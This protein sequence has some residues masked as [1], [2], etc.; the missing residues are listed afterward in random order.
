HLDLPSFPTRRSSD[1]RFMGY[2]ER[3]LQAAGGT[4]A[5][6]WQLSYVDLSLFQLVT[7]LRYAFP[8]TMARLESA[9]PALIALH[10][11]IAMRPNIRSEEHT[12][13]LQSRE[14]L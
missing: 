13:E 2:F 7:G 3:V 12:S 8:N 4:Y 14:N 6:G 1:L 9:W 11:R 5:L 10:D